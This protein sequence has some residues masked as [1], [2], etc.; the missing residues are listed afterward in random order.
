MSLARVVFITNNKY[1]KGF[2]GMNWNNTIRDVSINVTAKI[3]EVGGAISFVVAMF[4]PEKEVNIWDSIKEQVKYLVDASILKKELEE[5]DADL[6]GLKDTMQRYS[7]AK[8]YERA[9]FMATM[10][11]KTDDLYHKLTISS[12]QIHLIPF[13]VVASQLQLIILRERLEHGLEIFKEDNRDVWETELKTA[14]LNYFNFFKEV[15]PKWKVWRNDKIEIKCYTEKHPMVL[16][17][18]FSWSS[19]GDVRDKVT[20]EH[21]HFTQPLK[22]APNFFSRECNAHAERMLNEAIALMVSTLSTTFML[23]RYLP[24][25]EQEKANIYCDLDTLNQGPFGGTQVNTFDT[26][27]KVTGLFIREY[28]SIDGIQ[29]RYVDHEGNFIGN[30]NGG[31][32]HL[33]EATDTR[34]FNGMHMCF[35]NGIMC[36]IQLLYNDDTSSDVLG[37]RSGWKG[38][39]YSSKVDSEYRLYGGSFTKGTGPSGTS[40]IAVIKLQYRHKDKF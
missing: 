8:N 26:V 30:P 39:C 21:F 27:G 3:P 18:Y 16:P 7:N 33:L 14:H 20:E 24:G 22:N 9:G 17:P 40:G 29:F 32:A 37:N 13:T 25:R 34:Y 36:Q 6:R 1:T 19:Y 5:R 35:S 10:I 23:H 15:Y 28:N 12:N 2:K 31:E 38:E 11:G 4:W